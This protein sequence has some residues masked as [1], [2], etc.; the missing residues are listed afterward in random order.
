VLVIFPGGLARHDE[1]VLR[2]QRLVDLGDVLN[3]SVLQFEGPEQHIGIEDDDAV[4][5]DHLKAG[6]LMAEK[7]GSVRIEVGQPEGVR[8][9]KWRLLR[10]LVLIAQCFVLLAPS[11]NFSM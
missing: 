3:R 1:A 2:G 6:L 4:L 11:A 7:R 9:G 10:V 8:G 5:D